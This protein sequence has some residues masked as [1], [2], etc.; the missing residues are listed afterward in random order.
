[1]NRPSISIFQKWGWI[2]RPEKWGRV[3]TNVAGTQ[4]HRDAS[5]RGRNILGTHHPGDAAYKG[6]IIPFFQ[7]TQNS[8]TQSSGTQ[9]HGT[10]VAPC[11]SYIFYYA[12]V[13]FAPHS[14]VALLTGLRNEPL[15]LSEPSTAKT[16]K[17]IFSPIPTRHSTRQHK[18]PS[19]LS[20]FSLGK[21][22]GG[23]SVAVYMCSS[24]H[25]FKCCLCFVCRLCFVCQNICMFTI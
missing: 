1:M 19:Y 21:N 3:V 14:F 23:T 15:S 4:S 9:R 24:S 11:Q 13:Q 6:R 17:V 8:G 20:D 5:S 12:E 7:G 22:L 18:N 16:K 25:F 10:P 2:V